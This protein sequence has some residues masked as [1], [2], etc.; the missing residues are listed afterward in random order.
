MI[1]QCLSV[2]INPRPIWFI[3]I[4]FIT[5]YCQGNVSAIMTDQGGVN[6]Y[7]L[8]EDSDPNVSYIIIVVRRNAFLWSTSMHSYL[9]LPAYY[10]LTG[11]SPMMVN[12][13]T[14]CTSSAL[15]QLSV[16]LSWRMEEQQYYVYREFT[17][18]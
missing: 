11:S 10:W 18:F 14:A 12:N 8:P 16:A 6:T 5:D 4:I 15:Q 7:L 3:I 9:L 2:T 13:L 17:R 1:I